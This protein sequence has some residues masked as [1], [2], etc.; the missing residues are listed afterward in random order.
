[1]IRKSL[2]IY[3]FILFVGF[4]TGCR[5]T[6][7]VPEG[8]Y[9]LKK[10]S[11]KNKSDLVSKEELRPYIRQRT[12][13]KIFW[14][15]N[16][17]LG[18]YNLS[19]ENQEHWWNRWLR[20]IGEAPVLFQSKYVDQSSIQIKQS[21]V[22]KGFFQAIVTDTVIYYPTKRKVKVRYNIYPGEQYKI[23]DVKYK[24][25][26]DSI[27]KLVLPDSVNCLL[28]PNVAFSSSIHN[29]ER[30]RI[31][32]LLRRNG[33]YAFS[34]EYIWFLSDSLYGNYQIADSLMLKKEI[35]KTSA[36]LD[37]LALHSRYK[38]N[39]VVYNL[40]YIPLITANSEPYRVDTLHL[41][42]NIILYNKEP[43][44][45]P[46]VLLFSS[47]IDSGDVYDYMKVQRS[48]NMLSSLRTFNLVNIN[49]KETGKRDSAGYKLLDCNIAMA[50]AKAQFYSVGVEGTNSSGNFGI[51]T[52]FKYQHKN[53][54][55][56]AELFTF[57]ARVAGQ[58]QFTRSHDPFNTLEI[59]ADMGIEFPKFLV[60][61]KIE[62]FRRRYNP[63]TT[64]NVSYNYQK[65]PDY[66][67]TLGNTQVSYNW[68]SSRYVTQILTP[69]SFNYVKIPYVDPTFWAQI[70]SSL[71]R[72]SYEDHL[73]LN[74]AYA[75][76]FS[77]QKPGVREN[78][79]YFR[80]ALEEA[81]NI[82][83][84]TKIFTYT[85]SDGYK[86]LFNVRYA[87]YIKGEVDLHYTFFAGKINSIAYRCF[88]GVAYPYGNMEVLPFEKQYFSGGAN[89][90]RGWPVR[91]IGPGAHKTNSTEIFNQMGDM[92]LEMN[93]EYRFKLFWVLEGA[94]FVDAGN[95]WTTRQRAEV[96]EGQFDI[97]T[98]YN[99]IAV[100]TGA[101]LRMDF[102]YFLLRLD[103]GIQ[104]LDPSR[105]EGDRW[106]L[107]RY[108]LSTDRMAFNFAI[109]YPF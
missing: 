58:R 98:F 95:I 46:S 65:R 68:R 106:T 108:P 105:E 38:I 70:D 34:K 1:M 87:Q 82:L 93:A 83:N 54:F 42:N 86:T 90:I 12:N 61:V 28:K 75:Y 45:R 21:L 99:Q 53:I 3:L 84:A 44:I 92:K 72:Y 18:L 35:L 15:F 24:I 30:E 32:N 7:Y 39:S 2:S 29:A 16:F 103:L 66:I 71:L 50:R 51:G 96:P 104:A 10:V 37:S 31:T 13:D 4:I 8:E 67:R 47:Q 5:T 76:V 107:G 52:K 57:N 109:G 80:G 69:I 36:G 63:K 14:V 49:F 33:Y 101:G 26:D 91:G 43:Y 48:Q 88:L 22:N 17:H 20:D 97:N 73:I 19:G 9:L 94:V 78:F 100:G 40:N 79:W 89:G 11:I 59:G 74:A 85:S 25:E 77:Q 6:K 81:G 56:G 60:P 64:L 41:N 62:N 27:R 55:K 23:L 102:N